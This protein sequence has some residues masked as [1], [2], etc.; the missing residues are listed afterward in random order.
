MHAF[1]SVLLRWQDAVTPRRRSNQTY[2]V[3]R[4]ADGWRITA[5]HNTRYRPMRLPTGFALKT[6]LLGMRLRTV[7]SRAGAASQRNGHDL[8]RKGFR[9]DRQ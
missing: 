3:V 2:V 5:F 9:D 6:I 1:G 4:G 7:V 8:D